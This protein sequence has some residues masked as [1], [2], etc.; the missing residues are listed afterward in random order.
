MMQKL[1][2]RLQGSRRVQKVAIPA[3]TCIAQQI[4]DSFVPY[5]EP[6]MPMLKS[7]IGQILHKPE[8]RELLGKTVMKKA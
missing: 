7:L 3:I 8:E 4:E 2:Q 6:L 5:F 1:G